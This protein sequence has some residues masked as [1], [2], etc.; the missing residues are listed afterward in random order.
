MKETGPVGDEE[1]KS[2][3]LLLSSIL[4]FFWGLAPVCVRWQG[5]RLSCVCLDGIQTWI[6][7]I[8][9]KGPNKKKEPDSPIRLLCIE[10]EELC[11]IVVMW[12]KMS[13]KFRILPTAP[14]NL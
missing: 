5:A 10:R 12:K 3:R 6:H 11:A 8:R 14:E 9:R 13:Q 4:S 2:G 1:E 7:I